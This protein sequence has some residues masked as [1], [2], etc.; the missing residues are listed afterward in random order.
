VKIAGKVA[1]VTGAASGIG[2][3][4]AERFVHEGARGVVLADIR[5]GPLEDAARAVGGLAIHCD[6]TREADV[7]LMIAS[8][9][10]QLGPVDIFVSNAGIFRGGDEQTPDADWDLSWRLHV[11]AHVYAARDLMPKMAARGDGYFIVTSSAA[12]LL[13]HLD[14]ASYAVTKHAA[15]SF[16]EFLAIRHGDAG[17]KVSVL[18]PQQVRTAMTT[19]RTASVSAVDGRIEPEVVADCV[20]ECME[21]ERF[22]M[23]PHPS[24]LEYLQRKSADYDRWLGGMRRL[25]DKFR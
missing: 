13:S 18:C 4:L 3:T 19:D 24:V 6:A 11:M 17:V 10:Q 21:A 23:L 7:R 2:R 22:L 1:V 16:A 25:K 9:E 8:V 15:V 20:I 14:S 5:R 12:G